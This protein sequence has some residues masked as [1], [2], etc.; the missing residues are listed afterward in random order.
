MCLKI[1]KYLK[2][3]TVGKLGVVFK[4]KDRKMLALFDFVLVCLNSLLN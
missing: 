4:H 2:F 1:A 3:E